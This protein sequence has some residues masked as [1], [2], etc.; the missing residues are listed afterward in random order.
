MTHEEYRQGLSVWYEPT[1]G[2]RFLGK[3]VDEMPRKLGDTWVTTVAMSSQAYGIWRRAR[4]T[5]QVRM[6]VPAAAL[7][8]LHLDQSSDARQALE[9]VLPLLKN[10]DNGYHYCRGC[11]SGTHNGW[12]HAEACPIRAHDREVGEARRLVMAALGKGISS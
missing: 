8:C 6:S 7:H 11:P 5:G 1:P 2:V 10:A 3:T 4:D 12:R 9:A